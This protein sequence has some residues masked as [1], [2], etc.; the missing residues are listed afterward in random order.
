MNAWD[1]QSK[2]IQPEDGIAEALYSGECRGGAV[3]V[4]SLAMG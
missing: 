4:M 1:V 2:H 3:K